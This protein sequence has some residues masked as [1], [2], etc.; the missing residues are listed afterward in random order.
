MA[1]KYLDER[2]FNTGDVIFSEGDTTAEMFIVQEGTVALTKLVAGREVFLGSQG[3][4]DFFGEMSMLNSSPR[5]ATC[6][7][8]APTRLLALRSGELLI[9]LR[10]DPTFALE[11][12]QQMSRRLAYM[13][14][15][16]ALLI[17]HQLEARQQLAK[18]MAKAEFRNFED[19][20]Q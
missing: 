20:Q 3:R 8:M 4:G 1:V 6:V 18:V 2:T 13:E 19:D 7:A 12:V 17:E 10:R 15:Q 14:E 16:V 9:K 11:M 5:H